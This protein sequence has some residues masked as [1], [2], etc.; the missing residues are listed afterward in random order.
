MCNVMCCDWVVGGGGG[1]V[2]S[3]KGGGASGNLRCVDPF[4][5]CWQE[6]RGRQAGWL[7]GR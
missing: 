7:V 2:V 4:N 3:H 5:N 1:V 6:H